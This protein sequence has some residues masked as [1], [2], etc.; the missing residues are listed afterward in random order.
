MELFWRRALSVSALYGLLSILF[1]LPLFV[2]PL[3]LGIADWDRHLFY[4]AE[5]LKNVVEYGQPPFWS[6][7][8][9]GGNVMWQNP[10]VAIFSPLYLLVTIVPLA[11]AMKVN[12]VLHYWIGFLGMH[13]LLT[14]VV[15]LT[16]V[17]LVVYAASVF[18]L[19]GSVALHLSVGHS[20]FLPVFYLPWLLYFLYRAFQTGLMRHALAAA[21]VLALTIDNGGMHIV[22]MALLAMGALAA[23]TAL[24]VRDWR[25]LIVVVF[26]AVCGAAYA[27]PKLV[28]IA[29]FVTS[30]RFHDARDPTDHPDRMTGEMLWRAYTDGSLRAVSRIAGEQRHDWSEYGNYVGTVGVIAIALALMWPLVL[31][32]M[33]ERRLAVAIALIAASFLVLSAGEFH[34]FAPARGLTRVG[35]FSSFRIPSRYTIAFVLFGAL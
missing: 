27:A 7:W 29:E 20:T 32:S 17:P 4:Y 9:C 28:P 21:G 8:Y 26:V 11:L 35:L 2:R 13:R 23:G 24:A 34:P 14:R 16:F 15:G 22:P 12:I 5:V 30:D 3:G 25:P 19:A 31:P 6:P 1:C 10:Q 33:P 18:T